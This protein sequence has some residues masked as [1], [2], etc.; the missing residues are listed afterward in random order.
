FLSRPTGINFYGIKVSSG[1]NCFIENNKLSNGPTGG[2]EGG[3]CVFGTTHSVTVRNNFTLNIENGITT[4]PNISGNLWVYNNLVIN[5]NGNG[6]PFY[7]YTGTLTGNMYIYNNII[8]SGSSASSYHVLRLR[9]L[10]V[11]TGANLVVKNNI[12]G[13]TSAESNGYYVYHP[14]T[15]NGTVTFDNNLYWNSTYASPFY[16]SGSG[17]SWSYWTDT[18]GYDLNSPNYSHGDADY[19]PVFNNISGVYNLDGDFRLQSSSPCI[20]AGTDVDVDV[21]YAN[22]IRTGNPD[23]GAFEY[24]T[25]FGFNAGLIKF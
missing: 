10:T 2:A 8:L 11:N 19:N 22:N 23:I 24:I 18:V 12:I 20:N 17:R 16:Y 5:D 14:A 25:S 3:I 7:A 21:D 6:D 15:N 13:F 4:I 9:L 1:N